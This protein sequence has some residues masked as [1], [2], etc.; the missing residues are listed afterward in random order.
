MLTTKLFLGFGVFVLGSIS[1]ENHFQHEKYIDLNTKTAIISK[2]QS[3]GKE[4]YA[5][6]CMQCHGANGKGDTKNFP[7]LAS[8]D[9]LKKKRNQSIAAVKFGQSGEI[10][11]NKIKYNSSMPAMGLSDQEVA[12]VMNY[13]M[14]SWSNK[15]TKVVTAKEVAAIKK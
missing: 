2:F 6:F 7:P 1:F 8:S 3:T 11:V 13:I 10:T 5:D 9:W 15:Q 12:D 4:I 14:T